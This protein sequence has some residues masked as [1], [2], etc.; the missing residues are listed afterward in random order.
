MLIETDVVKCDIPLL[1]SKDAMKKAAMQIDF[2]ADV[3][4]IFGKP[5]KLFFTSIGH[6]CI[7]IVEQ[8]NHL[9]PKVQEYL[10]LFVNFGKTKTQEKKVGKEVAPTIQPSNILKIEAPFK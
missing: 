9:R 5:I 6:Y 2:K 10:S 7:P 1:L 8:L 3:V 4:K